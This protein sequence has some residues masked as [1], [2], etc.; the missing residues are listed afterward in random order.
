MYYADNCLFYSQYSLHVEVKRSSDGS[1]LILGCPMMVEV[2]RTSD[3]SDLILGCPMME[4]AYDRG[5]LTRR[6]YCNAID[7]NK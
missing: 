1:D 2:K 6:Y 3:G 7:F 4:M 5:D